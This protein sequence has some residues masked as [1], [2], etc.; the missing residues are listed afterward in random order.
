MDKDPAR[1]Y[2]TAA[3]LA[4]DCQRFQRGEPIA[5]SRP[6]SL[7]RFSKWVRRRPAVAALV[8]AMV[9]FTIALAGGTLWLA[10]QQAHSRQ[11]V[12]GDLREVANLQQQARWTDARGALQTAEARLNGGG[13]GDLRERIDQARK[14]L[15]LVI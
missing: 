6:G 13:P 14:N 7:E 11:A 8:G 15:D 3:A 2:A 9:L 1:R 12:E 4:E 10:V 5:A